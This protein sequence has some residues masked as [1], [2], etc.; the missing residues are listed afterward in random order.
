MVNAREITPE[1]WIALPT[2]GRAYVPCSQIFPEV[3]SQVWVSPVCSGQSSASQTLTSQ[4]AE[5]FLV[6]LK[7]ITYVYTSY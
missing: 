5:N 1:T 6:L 3:S 7:Y 4:Y 2:Q